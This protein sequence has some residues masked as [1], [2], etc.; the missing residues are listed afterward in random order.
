MPALHSA[1]M[2]GNMSFT[3]HNTKHSTFLRDI[4]CYYY[5]CTHSYSHM[6]TV[7]STL[8]YITTYT[9]EAVLIINSV[10]M[11]IHGDENSIAQ[12]IPTLGHNKTSHVPRPLPKCPSFTLLHTSGGM[13]YMNV[14]HWI[15]AEQNKANHHCLHNPFTC[16]P[17]MERANDV[18]RSFLDLRLLPALP[19]AWLPPWQRHSPQVS[20]QPIQISVFL[21]IEAARPIDGYVQSPDFTPATSSPP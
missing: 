20:W 5:L 16:V 14:W 11:C 6:Y 10:P 2:R 4:Y 15:P 19:V 13:V 7:R 8:L 12:L 3:V 17:A 18:T 21:Q 9:P 1:D